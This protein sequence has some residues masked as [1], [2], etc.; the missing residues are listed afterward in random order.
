VR[1]VVEESQMGADIIAFTSFG[2]R[3]I[4]VVGHCEAVDIDAVQ[5][6]YAAAA[7]HDCPAAIVLTCSDFTPRA[8][9]LSRK[10]GVGLMNK[11]II[12]DWRSACKSDPLRRG[13]RTHLG[14]DLTTGSCVVF[15]H[16]VV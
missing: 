6:A 12:A 2:V 14:N 16:S 15:R 10:I 3:A 5:Q 4:R 7:Y 8:H 1:V 11:D 9:K 13:K